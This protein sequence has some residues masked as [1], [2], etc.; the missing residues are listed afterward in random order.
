MNK[1]L[2]ALHVLCCRVRPDKRRRAAALTDPTLTLLTFQVSPLFDRT[3]GAQR[4]QCA[5]VWHLECLE[6]LILKL[7]SRSSNS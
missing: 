2:V 7:V 5:L 3:L 4:I 6:E 1:R